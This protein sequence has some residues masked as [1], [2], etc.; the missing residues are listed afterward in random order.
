MNMNVFLHACPCTTC[1]QCPQRPEEGVGF[2]GTGVTDICKPPCL[3]TEA[4]SSG[5]AVSTPNC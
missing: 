1:V 4:G 2:S 3:G 5:G